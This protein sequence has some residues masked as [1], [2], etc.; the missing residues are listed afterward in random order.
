MS[1]HGLDEH[2]RLRQQ[3][4]TP[5]ALRSGG[6]AREWLDSLWSSVQQAA[7]GEQGDAD[8]PHEAESSAAAPPATARLLQTQLAPSMRVRTSKGVI[9][10][11][12]PDDHEELMAHPRMAH[13]LLPW[14]SRAVPLEVPEDDLLDQLDQSCG[15]AWASKAQ[16]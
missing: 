4:Q 16:S 15:S 5:A 13:S 11:V 14:A 9:Q 3:A 7:P 10:V 6:Q 2:E 1:G 8:E 12:C